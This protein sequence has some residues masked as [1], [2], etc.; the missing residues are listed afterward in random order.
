MM[1]KGCIVAW[2]LPLRSF[3]ILLPNYINVYATIMQTFSYLDKRE[4]LQQDYSQPQILPSAHFWW[5]VSR[6]IIVFNRGRS[7]SSVHGDGR[8]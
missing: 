7:H 5:V 1:V 3:L 4:V 6:H 2:V 8:I